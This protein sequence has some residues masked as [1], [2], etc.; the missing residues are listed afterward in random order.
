ML[1]KYYQPNEMYLISGGVK[2]SLQ[3]Q[4]WIAIRFNQV[5]EAYAAKVS[6]SQGP[7]KIVHEM[8]GSLLS[9]VVY[10]FAYRRGYGHPGGFNILK[11]FPR[12]CL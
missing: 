10:G 8:E 4:S 7:V 2:K 9:A 12:E 11:N 3:S 5:I 6:I 1:A